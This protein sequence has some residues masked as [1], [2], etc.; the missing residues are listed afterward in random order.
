MTLYKTAH[1]LRVHIHDVHWNRG[2]GFNVGQLIEEINTLEG[3]RF[4]C[5]GCVQK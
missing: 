4:R 1:D 2:I 5:K 3:I